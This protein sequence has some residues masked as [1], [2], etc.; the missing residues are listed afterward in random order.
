MREFL[1]NAPIVKLKPFLWAWCICFILL[2]IF[3]G[4][5]VSSRAQTV[6]DF[7][8]FYTA[9]F[10]S[11]TSPSHLY[12]LHEQARVQYGFTSIQEFLPFYHPSYEP[13][14]L[15][16]FSLLSYRTAFRVYLAFNMLL[17][18]A[19]F[20][21][22]GSTF[23]PI[24]PRWQPRPGLMFFV[25]APV[26]AA[27]LLG[28]DSILFLLLCCLTWRQLKS[29][30][31]ISAA[32]FLALA[33]FK[34]QIALPIAALIALRQGQKFFAGFA[35][36][37]ICVA[38]FS[39]AIVGRSGS[40]E[41][42]HVLINASS[43]IDKNVFSQ[44]GMGIF[45][46]AMPNI[47][48][49]FYAVGGRFLSSSGTFNTIISACS[50]SLLVW[51]AYVIRRAELAVAFSISI[52]CGLLISY[53]LFVYDLT[54]ALLP[55]ALLAKHIP[56]IILLGLFGLPIVLF[57]FESK[58]FFILAIPLLTMLIYTLVSISSFAPDK[59]KS[60]PA[61]AT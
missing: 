11:R 12:D 33:L 17:L 40:I 38:A 37:S 58:W 4:L 23:F 19:S 10:L 3:G 52:L 44:Q 16:P 25:F 2:E 26:L 43:S 45:P 54:L 20:F 61:T 13:F 7:P 15:S 35:F 48:G 53:H 31:D 8:S 57:A 56:K 30:D 29:G 14:L 34:F 18:L 32:V 55:I 41:Y 22:A 9:E 46:L 42:I 51:C 6:Y 21:A 49:L 59:A 28:Q 47:A 39:I 27:L 36:A 1:T 24:I 60:A 50:F 5:F